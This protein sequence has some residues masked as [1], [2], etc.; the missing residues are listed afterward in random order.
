M[1]VACMRVGLRVHIDNVGYR[2]NRIYE[3]GECVLERESDLAIVQRSKVE[4]MELFTVGRLHIDGKIMNEASTSNRIPI[5]LGSLS[6]DEQRKIYRKK[7][8]VTGIQKILGEK[9]TKINIQQA[10]KRV[11]EYL[12]DPKAPSTS[13]VWRWWKLWIESDNNIMVFLGSQ[14]TKVKTRFKD[15][16]SKELITEAIEE[17]YLTNQRTAIQDVYDWL[18]H[19]FNEI[20]RARLSPLKI[21]SRATFYRI[22]K[23]LDNYERMAAREGKIVADKHF[24]TVGAGV[25]TNYILERV[26][27]DHTPLDVMVINES[28]KL[29]D[30]RPWITLLLDVHSK[31]V[32]GFSIG[33]EPPSELSVMDALRSA[34]LPKID[35]REKYPK[36]ECEWPAY[37]IPVVLICDNGSEFHSKNLR[38]VCAELNIELQFCPKLQPNYKG[39]IE[40]FLGTLNR[41]VCHRIP[42]S[43]FSSVR[44]RNKYKSEKMATVTLKELK[45]LI[46]EWIIDIY[47]HETNRITGKTPYELW[48]GGL[49]YRQPMLP[50]SIVHL[51][52]VLSKE[53]T[54]SINHEGINLYGLIYNSSELGL[55]R[56]RSNKTFK[57]T[58]RYDVT[59]L[60]KIWVYDDVN[61][62]FIAVPS[63]HPEYTTG[64]SLLEHRG[65]RK[66]ERNSIQ[67][68]KNL[69]ALLDRK[70]RFTNDLKKQSKEKSLR[71]RQ[72]AARHNIH[73]TATPETRLGDNKINYSN[74]LENLD[75]IDVPKFH[76][77]NRE[78][79]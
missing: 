1:K 27:V 17:H 21:P 65:V 52:L 67:S 11:A 6:E 49:L 48:N 72:K 53:T 10:I 61:V 33:F 24:R 69:S 30:G 75:F 45:S 15:R 71:K 37:G 46:H 31:M 51:G 54:R 60:E 40:R 76:V 39:S 78:V 57:V 62:D 29:V 4:L 73:K 68:Q 28:T 77:E 38:R 22:I 26:E 32:L 59:N 13:S 44:H 2:I 36:V 19:R 41:S 20:N 64:L 25:Q 16:V 34:I 3:S 55:L 14:V 8:Y 43:T 7:E 58:I 74:G 23:N 5:D 66:L 12:S 47:F 18:C 50:E 9:P 70:A 56:K 42:G 79:R 63:V 35:I